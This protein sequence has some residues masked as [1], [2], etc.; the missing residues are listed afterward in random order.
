MTSDS[1]RILVVED[2]DTLRRGIAVA[3]RERWKDVQEVASGSDAVECIA[4]ARSDT[5]DVI[6]TDLRLPGCDGVSVLRAARERDQL[7]GEVWTSRWTPFRHW[8]SPAG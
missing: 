1:A 8:C 4:D 3:L 2:N 7:E 6:V 5:F